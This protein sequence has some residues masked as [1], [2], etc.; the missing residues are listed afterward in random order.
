MRRSLVG[1]AP[2]QG[3]SVCLDCSLTELKSPCEL[4]RI[5]RSFAFPCLQSTWCDAPLAFLSV[6]Y[7]C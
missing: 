7:T 4:I 1:L 2:L 5:S 6:P 3:Y